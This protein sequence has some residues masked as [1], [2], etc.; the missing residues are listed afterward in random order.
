MLTALFTFIGLF[1]FTLAV[2]HLGGILHSAII[3]AVP[4]IITL[5][6]LMLV[7]WIY[8]VTDLSMLDSVLTISIAPMLIILYG[9]V[10]ARV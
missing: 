1:A 4:G 3:M 6:M 7:L 9:A 8:S 2:K 5:G 10:R